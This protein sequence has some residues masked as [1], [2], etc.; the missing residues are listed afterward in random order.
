MSA[1]LGPPEPLTRLRTE[2]TRKDAA[3]ALTWSA[4]LAVLSYVL[5]LPVMHEF[6]LIV[7]DLFGVVPGSGQNLA[8]LDLVGCC[9]NLAYMLVLALPFWIG[10][11]LAVAALRRGGDG[12]AGAALLLNLILGATLVGF[13]VLVPF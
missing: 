5:W 1:R 2:V 6:A 11:W 9:A 7:Y 10:A 12:A 8:S 4:H 13:G 3:Q